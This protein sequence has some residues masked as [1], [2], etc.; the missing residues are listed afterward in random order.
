M[1]CYDILCGISNSIF[2][3]PRETSY[4]K[5][6]KV[7]LWILYNA[8]ISR[9]HIRVFEKTSELHYTPRNIHTFVL[10]CVSL[11]SVHTSN[12]PISFMVTSL[13]L[14]C[15]REP[16]LMNQ[17]A[18]KRYND[19][20]QHDMHHFI[21]VLTYPYPE[22]YIGLVNLCQLNMCQFVM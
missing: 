22:S 6:W 14:N 1:H 2:E 20:D 13:A 15:N 5:H 10:C 19:I 3:I 17:I 7:A 12:L 11:W 18:Q 4:P 8:D 9:A 21:N 16:S